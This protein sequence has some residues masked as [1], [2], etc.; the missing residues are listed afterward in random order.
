MNVPDDVL[1]DARENDR[2]IRAIIDPY[3]GQLTG[4]GKFELIARLSGEFILGGLTSS[5]RQLQARALPLELEAGATREVERDGAAA[6]AGT[7][8]D[9]AAQNDTT[10]P[11]GNE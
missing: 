9:D 2:R 6:E 11:K 10:N 1:D 5:P 8:A 7:E 4:L 3:L